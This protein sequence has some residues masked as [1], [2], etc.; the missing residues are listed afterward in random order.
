MS[1]NFNALDVIENLVVCWNSFKV[2][3]WSKT[4]DEFTTAHST[5]A[6]RLEA[7]EQS[8]LKFL[9]AIL[10]RPEILKIIPDPREDYDE[11]VKL[12]HRMTREFNGPYRCRE[13][14]DEDSRLHIEIRRRQNVKK[15]YDEFEPL[16]GKLYDIAELIEC[17]KQLKEVD[18]QTS[19]P[20]AEGTVDALFLKG[21]AFLAR[22]QM[23][24]EKPTAQEIAQHLGIARS[25]LYKSAEFRNLRKKANELFNLFA[26]RTL[27]QSSGIPRGSKDENGTV[28]AYE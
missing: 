1:Q 20:S 10:R 21:I 28:E 27:K 2:M 14:W 25:T 3:A 9:D 19:E 7:F 12:L 11:T 23:S 15:V 8:R 17:Q 5:L 18:R 16:F 24:E 22:C 6:I 13:D 26:E 4:R